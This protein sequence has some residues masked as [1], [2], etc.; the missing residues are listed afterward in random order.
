MPG[1]LVAFALLLDIMLALMLGAPAG[2]GAHQQ[3]PTSARWVTAWGT[4]QSALGMSTMNHATVRLIAGVTIPG[5]AVRIRLDNTFAPTPLSI[6]KAYPAH[7]LNASE[8]S[9]RSRTLQSR[10][11]LARWPTWRSG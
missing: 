10:R 3:L 6:G 1:R 9:L 5:H 8:Q 11:A 4:S 7:Q 2:I